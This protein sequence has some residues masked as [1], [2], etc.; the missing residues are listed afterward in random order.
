MKRKYRKVPEFEIKKKEKKED[1]GSKKD[2]IMIIKKIISND[3]I[4]KLYYT[5]SECQSI[6]F[7]SSL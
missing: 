1:E 6:T 4:N 2:N 3:N 5:T 7:M